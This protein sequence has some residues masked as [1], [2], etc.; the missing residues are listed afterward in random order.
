MFL[1]HV[2]KQ[3]LGSYV[4]STHI[5]TCKHGGVICHTYHLTDTENPFLNSAINS[6]IMHK[7]TWLLHILCYVSTIDF[8]VIMHSTY[9]VHVHLLD[10]QSL[11]SC[12]IYSDAKRLMFE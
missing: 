7:P 9:S 12:Y 5:T 3:A 6:I 8:S 10:I 1:E 11:T 4:P 2:S